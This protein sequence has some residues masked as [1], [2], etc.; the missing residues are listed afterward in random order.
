MII[1]HL[2][3]YSLEEKF[4]HI[5]DVLLKESIELLCISETKLNE[6]HLQEFSISQYRTYRRDRPPHLWGKGAYGGGLITWVRGSVPSRCRT[7]LESDNAETMCMELNVKKWEMAYNMCI[8]PTLQLQWYFYVR[9]YY[10]GRQRVIK[11]WLYHHYRRFKQR[12]VCNKKWCKQ[13]LDWIYEL[14]SY[15]KHY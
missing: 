15:V 12:S 4:V 7:D 2:N 8:Q 1:G 9:T 14:T 10:N 3:I 5:E 11:L 6:S 13:T